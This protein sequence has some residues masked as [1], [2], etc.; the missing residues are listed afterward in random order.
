M[1]VG[2]VM[3]VWDDETDGAS[4]GM[5]SGAEDFDIES[6]SSDDDISDQPS[7]SAACQPSTASSSRPSRSAQSTLDLS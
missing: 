5:S 2:E 3:D 1:D 7:T 4:S 6:E